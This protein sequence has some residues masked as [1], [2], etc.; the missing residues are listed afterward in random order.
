MFRGSL[1]LGIWPEKLVAAAGEIGSLG[2]PAMYI[3]AAWHPL[4][5]VRKVGMGSVHRSAVVLYLCEQCRYISFVSAPFILIKAEN[6][7][8]LGSVQD[9]WHHVVVGGR[10]AVLKWFPVVHYAAVW[11]C[12]GC[13]MSSPT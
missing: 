7:S 2:R 6:A 9:L 13:L 11:G 12:S 3:Q 10:G 4:L 8:G 1:R 5:K